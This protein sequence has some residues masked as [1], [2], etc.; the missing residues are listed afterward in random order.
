MRVEC[1]TLRKIFSKR[2]KN[3]MKKIIASVLVT[4]MILAALAT[5]AVIPASAAST[6]TGDWAI[7]SGAS[8]Y[9]TDAEG[10]PDYTSV[11]DAPVAGYEY[12]EDGLVVTSE[13]SS[14]LGTTQRFNIMTKEPQN[15]KRGVTMTVVVNEMLEGEDWWH[16]FCIWDS[17]NLAQGDQSGKYGNGYLNLL[18]GQ[19]NRTKVG[20]TRENPIYEYLFDGSWLQLQSFICDSTY[21]DKTGTALQP[22]DATHPMKWNVVDFG[23]NPNNAITDPDKAPV[24]NEDGSY[25]LTMKL[26]WDG[27]NYRLFFCGVEVTQTAIDAYLKE[28]FP[29]GMA[30]IGYALNGSLSDCTSKV[31]ITEFNGVKPTGTDKADFQANSEEVGEIVPGSEVPDDEPV[32]LFDAANVDDIYKNTGKI[33]N[34]GIE[35]GIK[36]DGSFW[37]KP[38]TAAASNFIIAPRNP[39]SYEASEFPFV[40]ILLRNFCT[41][42]LDEEVTECYGSETLGMY[43]C[44][45]EILNPTDARMIAAH[46]VGAQYEDDY[47]NSYTLFVFDM[48]PDGECEVEEGW[49]GRINKVEFVFNDIKTE[50]VTQKQFDM[51][52]AAFFKSAD[53]AYNYAENYAAEYEMCPHNEEDLEIL[54]AIEESCDRM[55]LTEGLKCTACDEILVIQEPIAAL[56]HDYQ[57]SEAI[58]PTCTEAGREAGETCTRCG[59]SNG[60]PIKALGHT[61]NSYAEKDGGH[62]AI[63]YRCDYEGETVEPHILNENNVCTLCG[64]GCSHENTTATEKKAPTC[65]EDGQ[66]EVKCNDCGSV[67]NVEAIAKLGHDNT[68]EIPAKAPDCVNTGL[69]QGFRCS[70]EGCTHV[71][72]AQEVVPALG[73]D[74]EI[75]PAVE[76]TC[77]SVGYTEGQTCKRENCPVEDKV[78]VAITEVPMAAHTYDG[79]KDAECNVC[80]AKRTLPTEAPSKQPTDDNKDDNKN[81]NNSGEEEKKGCGSA[82]GLGAFAIIASV[83]VAG[84]FS[85]KKKED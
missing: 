54:P 81:D 72:V 76:A 85:F 55:G 49:S 80:G 36:K 12:T 77:K 79:E 11:P 45:G 56:G 5:M 68:V 51:V 25:T 43:Y 8:A 29:D 75:T 44:A 41:C 63:C 65:T 17:P 46:W 9:L 3:K 24:V 22:G 32:L 58:E 10:N 59:A 26:E 48:T 30:Y 15:L 1:G 16:S 23:T 78:I 67:V 74:I 18:R 19:A 57:P 69:T 34:S 82:I 38:R 6:D 42:Q 40:A 61:A 70:R 35:Y 4:V 13:S 66:R 53:A 50:S 60:S 28:R 39:Y 83:A 7:Y 33:S 71:G 47:G 52:Y 73:H 21:Y 84:A 31:T 62:V 27:Q 20:G 37:F 64:A 14:K 2:R